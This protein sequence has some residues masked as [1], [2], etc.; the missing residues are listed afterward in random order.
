VAQCLL[1]AVG[2]PPTPIESS[3]TPA[4]SPTFWGGPGQWLGVKASS[5]LQI[6]V[7]DPLTLSPVCHRIQPCNHSLCE[8]SCHA[9]SGSRWGSC[10]HC[11]APPPPPP[12]PT[13]LPR[14]QIRHS[15]VPDGCRTFGSCNPP[16]PRSPLHTPGC[17]RRSNSPG[18]ASTGST[19]PV[20][21]N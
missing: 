17:C 21:S 12:L 6:R 10:S 7:L 16:G 11:K 8:S 20:T 18:L 5:P 4:G 9:M 2:K 14:S 19:S 3:T 13:S 15:C 1:G